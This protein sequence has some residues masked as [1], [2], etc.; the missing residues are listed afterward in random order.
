MA[1]LCLDAGLETL[2]LWGGISAATF[3][4]D[5]HLCR[6]LHKG[7][8]S[9]L[10]PSQGIS[11]GSIGRCGALGTPCPPKQPTAYCPGVQ[12]LHSPKANPRH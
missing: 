12:G 4:R 6:H 8:P 11:S 9:L 10:P 2:H 1:T 3:T 7:S 5:L